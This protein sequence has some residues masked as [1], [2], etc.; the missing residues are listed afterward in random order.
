[1][2]FMAITAV[3][4]PAKDALRLN[5]VNIVLSPRLIGGPP[6]CRPTERRPPEEFAMARV[7]LYLLIPCALLGT[8]AIA[9]VWPY[10]PR[11]AEPPALSTKETLDRLR[12]MGLRAIPDAPGDGPA[13]GYWL[14]TPQTDASP[15]RL[16]DLIRQ[17]GQEANWGGAVLMKPE[18]HPDSTLQRQLEEWGDAGLYVRPFVFFGDPPL[19][20]R[21]AD[22][23]GA[24]HSATVAPQ[25]PT[26]E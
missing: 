26:D 9:A 17:R 19:V 16:A 15:D 1:M 7:A 5:L 3:Q 2:E 22:A 11:P 24:P 20:G 8:V 6:A 21:I 12:A 13:V 4:Q 18:L 10:R 25:A 14:L 23:L